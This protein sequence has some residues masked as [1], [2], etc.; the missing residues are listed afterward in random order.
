[1]G[2]QTSIGQGDGNARRRPRSGGGRRV[3]R[4]GVWVTEAEW[5]AIQEHAARER[6]YPSAYVRR[7]TLAVITGRA[8]PARE[9]PVR[10]EVR[11][12]LFQI[13]AA[14]Q[15]VVDRLLA[16]QDVDVQSVL[17]RLRAWIEARDQTA[18]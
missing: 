5:T 1:M 18:E 15:E 12:Q 6:E 8:T 10:A 9:S 4:V 13:H 16:G 11:R 3:R 14:A 7:A 17:T 2:R